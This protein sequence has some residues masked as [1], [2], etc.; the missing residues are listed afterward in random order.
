METEKVL[1]HYAKYKET[2]YRCNKNWVENNREKFN[3]YMRAHRRKHKEAYD[4][5]MELE[6][7]NQ[8]KKK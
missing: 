3:A 7:T 5:L 8:I 1:T 4:K 2:S 6:K